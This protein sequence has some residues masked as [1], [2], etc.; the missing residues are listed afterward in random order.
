MKILYCTSEA[1]PFAATGGL[2]DVAGSL[3]QALRQRLIGCRVVMPLYEDIPQEMRDGMK[4]VTSLSVPVAWR[5]QYC[6][7]FEAR[8]GGVIYYLIDNQYYFKRKGLYGHYDDA[9]RFAFLSRA[10]LEMLPYLDFKPDIIH[11]N[12]WQTAM[13]PIYYSLF[14]ANND[15]YRGIKTVM[16]IHNIQYQGKYGKELVEDVLGL[17]KSDLPILEYDDCVNMLKGAIETANRVTTVSPT[18]AKEI[19]DPWYSSGLDGILNQRAWKLSGILNGIDTQ[20][21]NP[22]TDEEIYAPYTADDLSGKAANK[23]ALQER[24][25]LEQKADVPLVGMVTRLVSHKGLDLVKEDLDCLMRETDMQFVVLGSGDWEYEKFFQEM[26]SRYPGRLCACHGF[27]PELSRKIYAGA[28]IFLMPSKSEPCGLS[29]MIALRYG[30]IPVVRET[31]G[32]KDSIQDSGDGKGNGFTFQNYDS[33]D[34]NHAVRRAL[35]GYREPEGWK[36]LVQRAMH[37]DMSW[38]K[39]ANEYIRMY[40]NLLKAD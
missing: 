31:G 10:A 28:D 36:V 20:S 1:R 15:W 39:S 8:A 26:Q 29:Q 18:Y 7:V 5:R 21:Y 25:G 14:Y 30:T 32:L 37:C 12:D 34:M 38:G 22:E 3:P 40:R 11:C 33:T 6:G 2:A 4:F 35:D 24:L 17:P 19:L 9:E 23:Q 13:V 16:T 27:V